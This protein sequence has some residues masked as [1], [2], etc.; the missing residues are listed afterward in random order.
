MLD[1][2]SIFLNFEFL[3]KFCRI[4]IFRT[5]NRDL[6]AILR[7]ARVRGNKLNFE[8]KMWNT[9][10]RRFSLD[11]Y[12][13]ENFYFQIFLIKKAKFADLMK[14]SKIYFICL[15]TFKNWKYWK[16]FSCKW[17]FNCFKLKFFFWKVFNLK[18]VHKSKTFIC[19]NSL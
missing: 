12:L 2:R 4:L 1:F 7:T 6:R 18:V 8:L 11:Y 3:P 14:K 10:N 17:L 9:Q 5:L 19:V 15:K 13:I 16:I